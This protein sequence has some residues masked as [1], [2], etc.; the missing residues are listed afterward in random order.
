[1]E[2]TGKYATLFVVNLCFPHLQNCINVRLQLSV[3]IEMLAF[4]NQIW[5]YE[6]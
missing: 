5:I 2:T 4:S 3:K 1:M 6:V